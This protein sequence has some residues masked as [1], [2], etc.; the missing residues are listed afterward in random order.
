MGEREGEVSV[1]VVEMAKLVDLHRTVSRSFTK[2]NSI[3][4]RLGAIEKQVMT[5]AKRIPTVTKPT[6]AAVTVA[7]PV[8]TSLGRVMTPPSKSNAITIRPPI[9]EGGE[10]NGHSPAEVLQKVRTAIP[11]AVAAQPLH[12]GDIHI[13]MASSQQKE[14]TL[15]NGDNIGQT[16]RVK[17]LRQDYPVEV[18]AVPTS[19]P[20]QHGKTADNT[21]VI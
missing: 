21:D 8:M 2:A 15:N 14:A 7:A 9:G 13:T 16:L 10:Y 1:S 19:V 17:V 12:S 11:G 6:W 5:L 18:Q 3:D 4:K 20:I